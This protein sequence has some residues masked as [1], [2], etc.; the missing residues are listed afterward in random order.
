M[1]QDVVMPDGTMVRNVPD[2]VTKD[3]V[4][5]KFKGT[6]QKFKGTGGIAGGARRLTKAAEQ[7]NFEDRNRIAFNYDLTP[8]QVDI[9]T[10]A[11]AF[12]RIDYSFSDTDEEI[13]GKFRTKYPGGN[14]QRIV[15]PEETSLRKQK[16]KERRV[17]TKDAESRLMFKYDTNDPDENWKTIED[18]GRVSGGDIADLAGS[19]PEVA[20]T[21][22][23]AVATG[24]AS[25]P[26]Q[27][28]AMGGASTLAHLGKEGV[29]EL[30]GTQM[31][32]F[33]DVLKTAFKKGAL[34]SAAVGGTGLA[35]KALNPL[36]GRGLL[37]TSPENVAAQQNIERS[38]LGLRPLMAHQ[39]EPEHKILQRFSRQAFS[40]S[41]LGAK[42]VALQE[43]SAYAG[44]KSLVDKT[45]T[46]IGKPLKR[47]SEKAFG[48]KYYEA[49]K[50]KVTTLEKGGEALKTGMKKDF[51]KGSKQVVN[52]L[53]K[54]VDDAA[55]L[56]KPVFDLKP[57][58]NQVDDI[59][60]SVIAAGAEGGEGVSIVTPKGELLDVIKRI[61][62]LAPEQAN[63]EAV[64]QLRT[65]LFKLIDNQPWAWDFNKF[66]ARRLWDAL[67]QTL[68]NPASKAPLFTKAFKT[69]STANRERMSLLSNKNI[70]QIIKSERPSQLA[71]IF[72]SPH[73]MTKEVYSAMKNYSPTRLREF[74]RAAQMKMLQD[75]K[76]AVKA[77]QDFKRIH[78][79]GFDRL[80]PEG[81]QKAFLKMAKSM[82]ELSSTRVAETLAKQTK[83]SG[84]VDDLIAKQDVS[85]I[86]EVLR[87]YGGKNT[88]GGKML[89]TGVMENI[90]GRVT[91]KGPQGFMVVNKEKL[92]TILKEFDRNG[93]S[94]A[95]LTSTDRKKLAALDDYL[96]LL[97]IGSDAGTSLEAAQAITQLKHPSTF[98]KGAHKLT[99]N[100]LIAKALTSPRTTKFLVGTGKPQLKGN[101]LKASAA[102]YA[103]IQDDIEAGE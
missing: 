82:D 76:G 47:L 55:R 102:T 33:K 31:E 90:I 2:D 70:Q 12:D 68:E 17:R 37:R 21:I 9:T 83:A 97:N 13:M 28:L 36:A 14:I 53:Y 18:Y 35:I 71:E 61:K 50:G 96:R 16:G 39:I 8:D 103:A 100:T 89:R 101:W 87:F 4:L 22:G 58:M 49:L 23:A 75:P 7:R 26:V 38:G 66:Q 29:E 65:D 79:E 91:E 32:S 95:V 72:S 48:K 46:Q 74:Q 1:P 40:T 11:K 41:T 25:L 51:V 52:A 6:G 44:I 45:A 34:T 19:F 27:A 42:E 54:N 93:I 10:G 80:V 63:H 99:I 60:K 73:A 77:A 94:K 86:E 88:A 64:K 62:A 69:A 92:N 84:F 67:T 43:K 15:L 56:E 30:R 85:G 98:I 57:V 5:Q 81:Q 20:A 59:E 3:Q 78:K 24:G